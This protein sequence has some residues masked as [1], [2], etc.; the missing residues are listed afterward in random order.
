MADNYLEKRMEDYRRGNAGKRAAARRGLQF[1]SASVFVYP[2]DAAGGDV[3][4]RT[5]VQAGYKVSFGVIDPVAG[6]VLAAGSG[7]RYYPLAP[8]AVAADLVARGENSVALVMLACD[9]RITHAA[10]NP[11][12]WI[13]VVESVDGAV[14]VMGQTPLAA[15]ILTAALAHPEVNL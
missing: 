15:A 7:A 10:L 14:S 11:S 2:A 12:R 5:L 13:S 1:P 4:L 6:P 8:A 9:C 3:M